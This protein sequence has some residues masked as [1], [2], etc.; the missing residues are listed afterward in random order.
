M[1]TTFQD[2]LNLLESTLHEEGELVLR[3]TTSL[4]T[5]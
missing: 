1:R 5:R 3:A 4:Q 2:E